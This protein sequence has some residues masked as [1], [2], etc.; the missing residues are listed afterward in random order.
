MMQNTN[1]PTCCPDCGYN[2]AEHTVICD[3]YTVYEEYIDC[4]RCGYSYQMA[5]CESDA[6]R[7]NWRS[8]PRR[9][10]SWIK[11]ISELEASK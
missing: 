8:W 4:R 2:E 6:I 10:F 5:M 7:G 3:E 9:F 1:N 11:R